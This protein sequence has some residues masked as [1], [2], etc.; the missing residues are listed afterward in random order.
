[1]ERVAFISCHPTSS[2][3]IA[4][5]PGESGVSYS[6]TRIIRP[7]TFQAKVAILQNKS[8]DDQNYQAL[9]DA[10]YPELKS[11]TLQHMYGTC[12]NLV[13]KQVR[14]EE[15][16]ENISTMIL[17]ITF[18]QLFFAQDAKTVSND[19]LTGTV[20]AGRVEVQ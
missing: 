3:I 17:D 20:D 18:E 14:H 9:M 6:D 19:E 13:V 8:G 2:V 11:F 7:A 10:S 5:H 15:T 1:M 16:A 4:T 12:S